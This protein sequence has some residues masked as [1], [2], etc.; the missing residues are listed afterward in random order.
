MCLCNDNKVNKCKT[1]VN[2]EDHLHTCIL[3]MKSLWIIVWNRKLILRKLMTPRNLNQI[4]LCWF[5]GL[6]FLRFGP[7]RHQ[8]LPGGSGRRARRRGRAADQHIRRLQPGRFQGRSAVWLGKLWVQTAGLGH[9]VHPGEDGWGGFQ[10]LN[11][12]SVFVVV[13]YRVRHRKLF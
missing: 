3:K 5:G 1:G 7:P 6:V 13:S 4:K 12:T 9:W 2:H 11:K 8:L 10:G